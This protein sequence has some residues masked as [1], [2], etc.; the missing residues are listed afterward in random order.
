MTTLGLTSSTRSSGPLRSITLSLVCRQPLGASSTS[1]RK[2]WWEEFCA[3]PW[4]YNSW[5]PRR[6][7]TEDPEEATQREFILP[8][9]KERKKEEHSFLSSPERVTFLCI[10]FWSLLT[11]WGFWHHPSCQSIK[12]VLRP[13][14]SPSP[15]IGTTAGICPPGVDPAWWPQTQSLWLSRMGLSGEK[16]KAFLTLENDSP[17]KLLLWEQEG[18]MRAFSYKV[19]T[20]FS[21]TKHLDFLPDQRAGETL[22]WA[23]ALHS[24]SQISWHMCLS[25][26][27]HGYTP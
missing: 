7:P 12:K 4:S 18:R 10:C 14:T 24:K 11:G 19:S 21:L 23:H 25:R 20:P 1:I 22:E 26:W 13:V 5:F 3:P 9:R 6:R 15:A 2:S 27:L 8:K 16:V 17:W